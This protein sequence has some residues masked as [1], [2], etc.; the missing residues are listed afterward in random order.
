MTEPTHRLLPITRDTHGVDIDLVYATDRNLTGKP[1]YRTA[2]CLL[3]EPA[4]AALRRAVAIAR[5]AGLSL[6]I[7]DAYR[8]PRAQQVLWDFL[9]DPTY[10]A[11]VKGGSNHS[12]GT[13]I[14]LTLLDSDRAALDMGT[15]FDDMTVASAHFHTGLPQAV[16]RNR[17]LLLGIME[18]AGFAHIPSEWWH[19]ELPGSRALPLID[20]GT[21]DAPALM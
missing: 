8:P 4:E 16:Q 19:Y 5:G 12:R 13:A 7:F 1:I 2:H 18:A 17:L 20:D 14:D 10:I 3:L 6:R 9:P 11:D 15:G 21:G